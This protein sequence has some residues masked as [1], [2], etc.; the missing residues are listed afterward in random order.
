MYLRGQ[1]NNFMITQI[2]KSNQ[3]I[4]FIDPKVYNNSKILKD[5]VKRLKKEKEKPY[6]KIFVHIFAPFSK[7]FFQALKDNGLKIKQGIS[8]KLKIVVEI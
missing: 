1:I 6:Q 5:L 3:T 8:N 2:T 4:I 7:E